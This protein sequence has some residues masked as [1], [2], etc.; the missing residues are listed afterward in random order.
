MLLMILIAGLVSGCGGTR[1][2]IE[3]AVAAALAPETSPDVWTPVLKN[4]SG[5]RADMLKGMGSLN[6]TS[7]LFAI[8]DELDK[9]TKGY[10]WELDPRTRPDV[11]AQYLIDHSTLV[12]AKDVRDLQW[13][14][15]PNG[16][17]CGSFSVDTS[18]GLKA[19][20]LFAA[21]EKDGS[22]AVTKLVVAKKQSTDLADGFAIFG[23]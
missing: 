21:S 22:I 2:K 4:P 10:S 23:K 7:F 9:L 20:M 19:K 8:T 13:A 6:F 15:Q 5:K 11:L 1:A 16:T 18:Y 17:F 3:R 14:R 12:A